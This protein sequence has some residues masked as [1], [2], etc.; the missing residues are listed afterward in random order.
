MQQHINADWGPIQIFRIII[1]IAM[2]L[3]M[4]SAEAVEW[5]GLEQ[6]NWCSGPKLSQ[7]K[8]AG[9]LVLVHRW[10]IH[11]EACIKSLPHIESLWNRFR[12]E[13]FII[14]GSHYHN[15]DVGKIDEIVKKKSLTYS[16]YLHAHLADEPLF[17]SAPFC[18]LVTPQG[19]VVYQVTGFSKSKMKDLEDVISAELAKIPAPGALCG[20]IAVAH[21]K[22]D[23]AKLLLG[24]NVEP[25]IKRLASA[26]SRGGPEADEA[27]KLLASVDKARN[28]LKRDIRNNAKMHRPGLALILLETL[29]KTWPSEKTYCA[30]ALRKLSTSKDV[31]AAVKLRQTLESLES[32]VPEN[33]SE[34]HK[35][36]S[37]KKAAIAA[38]APFAKSKYPGV[39][40]EIAELIANSGEVIH[41]QEGGM[42]RVTVSSDGNNVAA[43]IT[44]IGDDAFTDR[45]KV[46]LSFIEKGAPESYML[47]TN[48]IGVIQQYECSGMRAYDSPPTYHVGERTSNASVLWYASTIVHDAYHSKLYND[49]LKERGKP[50]PGEIWT[51]RE[52]ENA[53][54]SAQEDFLRAV[55]AP[56][57][58]IKHV[59]KMRDVDYFSSEVKRDW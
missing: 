7:A 26:A 12:K 33:S 48:Y 24:N 10:G 35:L 22:A 4:S 2:L 39:A 17:P 46:A 18:Y 45:T 21:F 59:R 56:E 36:E 42:R 25:V 6:E 41:S 5:R 34:A 3:T 13:G 38:A 40:E 44:I 49:Y 58:T 30:K 20:D 31:K 14:I 51:G 23:A 52:P 19:E 1:I 54:L 50:V 9:K 32:V 11:S 57:K 8:L 28:E 15:E 27:Q 16:I 47:V 53:C 29:V 55:N 43:S 37:S